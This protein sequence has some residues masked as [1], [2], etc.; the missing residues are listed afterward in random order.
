MTGWKYYN[1]ALLRDCAPHED[2][3]IIINNNV[4]QGGDSYTCKVDVKLGL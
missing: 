3:P 1:H 2:T 4:F